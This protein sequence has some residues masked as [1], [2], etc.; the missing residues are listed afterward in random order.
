M[1]RFFVDN[2]MN[3][4]LEAFEHVQFE[5]WR[6]LE[7]KSVCQRSYSTMSCSQE[8]RNAANERAYNVKVE[9]LSN[10]RDEFV[11]EKWFL[12]IFFGLNWSQV[13]RNW[14]K[15]IRK[16]EP[17]CLYQKHDSKGSLVFTLHFSLSLF[18]HH[19]TWISNG[20]WIYLWM[21]RWFCK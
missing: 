6:M 9:W 18:R 1:L 5:Y 12:L 7:G 21:T 3:S 19:K 16:K 4:A 17:Q 11:L 2:Q 14:G 20:W 10:F 15:C 8:E 13:E